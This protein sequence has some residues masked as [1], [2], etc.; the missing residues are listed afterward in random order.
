MWISLIL[1]IYNLHISRINLK[2][3][4]L[5]YNTLY[6]CFGFLLL[7]KKLDDHQ[8]WWSKITVC[9]GLLR[10]YF[11]R[12]IVSFYQINAIAHCPSCF[13][14]GLVSWCVRG[15]HLNSKHS[16]SEMLTHLSGHDENKERASLGQPV[17][18][19]SRGTSCL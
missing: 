14:A 11:C 4:W 19:V 2:L 12:R 17:A 1:H 6:V 15:C 18:L 10:V 5:H 13:C 7:V 3:T 9:P 8:E 16:A